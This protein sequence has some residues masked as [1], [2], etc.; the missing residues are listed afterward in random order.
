MRRG[1]T[2]L[3]VEDEADIASLVRAYLEDDGFQVIWATR[4]TDG[5][6]AFEE[7]DIRLA[8][9]DLQ[10]PDTDGFDVCRALRSCSRVPVVMLTARDEEVDR[11]MGLELGADDYVTKPFSP[12]ELVAR[13]HAVLRRAEPEVEEDVLLAGDIVLD[14]RS[15]TAI[16]DGV[17]VELTTR[18]FEL[19]WHLAERPGVVVSRERILERVWGLSFPGGTRTVDVHVGQLRRKLAGRISSGRS[20][21]PA[22]SWCRDEPAVAAVPRD[23]LDRGRV[24][25]RHRHRRSAPHASLARGLRRARARAAG[26]ADRSRAA[27]RAEQSADTALG[28]FLATDQQRLAILTPA[29]AALLLPEAGAERIRSGLPASGSVD[30]RGERFLY[31]ARSTGTEAIVLLRPADRQAADWWPFVVGLALAAA[32]GAAL[33]AVVALLLARAV[34]RPIAR[35]SAA[36]GELAAGSSPAPL[37]V[38]GPR[39]VARLAGSFNDLSAELQRSQDAERAFLLS[40]SHE[41]KTP[42]T[43]I[44]GHAEGVRDG[45]LEPSASGAVIEREARRL[46]RLVGDLLDLARLRRRSFSVAAEPLDLGELAE[47]AHERHEPAARSLGLRLEVLAEPDALAAGDPDRVLQA[48]SNLVENALRTTPSGG[49]VQILA[50][51]GR[52]EVVDDGRGIS[53]ADLPQAFERF[54]LYDRSSDGPRVGTGLGL[55]IVRELVEAMGGRV[56]VRSEVGVGSRFSIALPVPNPGPAAAR[57]YLGSASSL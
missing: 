50:G 57:R 32:V 34:A 16:V 9:L 33:A 26:G 41:L 21:A 43:S 51:P 47:A 52:L 49:S 40:V 6:Q 56:D 24:A 31:A 14:R 17:D 42:L 3:L 30:V 11:V 53:E 18:E 2:I 28:R 25:R 22:T 37:P 13:V 38:E 19:A 23:R 45:V 46:E 7:N 8:I 12:R 48:L 15:R 35:V 29:Q 1:G 20:G 36:S 4:G 27:R 5:L 10:L 39:E 55:A 54:Y 44:R